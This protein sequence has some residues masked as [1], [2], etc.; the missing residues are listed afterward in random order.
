MRTDRYLYV[1]YASREQELYD[2]RRDPD[3]LEN[4]ADE[5]AM[6]PVVRKLARELDRLRMCRSDGCATPLPADLRAR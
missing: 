2:L 1:E 4:L 3:Q 6:A 5:P